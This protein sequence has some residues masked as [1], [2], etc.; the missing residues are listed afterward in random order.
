MTWTCVACGRDN[1]EPLS[2]KHPESVEMLVHRIQ[3]KSGGDDRICASFKTERYVP[4]CATCK[5]PINYKIRPSNAHA[6]HDPNGD[7]IHAF[8]RPTGQGFDV[9]ST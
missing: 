3:R 1:R 4:V 2:T 6:F 7:A 9:T 8:T 5:T